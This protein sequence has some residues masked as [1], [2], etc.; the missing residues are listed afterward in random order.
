MKLTKKQTQAYLD[1][2]KSF[3]DK[4]CADWFAEQ[5][6]EIAGCEYLLR[7]KSDGTL[8]QVPLTSSNCPG[9][10]VEMMSCNT[11]DHFVKVFYVWKAFVNGLL[12]K[13]CE[14]IDPDFIILTQWTDD[15]IALG[16]DSFPQPLMQAAIRRLKEFGR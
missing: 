6:I 9:S 8:E 15:L 10:V 16:Y 14:G 1:Q 7:E 4:A 13:A 5:F 11:G 3:L 2:R 12:A